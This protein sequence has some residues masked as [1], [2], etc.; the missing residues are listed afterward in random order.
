MR[1]EEKSTAVSLWVSRTQRGR[2]LVI[3][4]RRKWR[5]NSEA[6]LQEK[7]NFKR[8]NAHASP[9]P[10]AN[11]CE[12][13]VLA[14]F[15]C[16]TIHTYFLRVVHFNVTALKRQNRTD[17]RRTSPC[18]LHTF[19]SVYPPHGQWPAPMGSWRVYNFGQA[20]TP[21]PGLRVLPYGS[22]MDALSN[23]FMI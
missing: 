22:E 10:L 16:F 18:I 20:A 4:V 7:N 19:Q 13:W 14:K 21:P 9:D 23:L 17:A 12:N 11:L 1:Q 3:W 8:P 6:L 5:T 2:P 15:W